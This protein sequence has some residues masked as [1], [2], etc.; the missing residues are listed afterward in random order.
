MILQKEKGR[1]YGLDDQGKLVAE[2]TY[3]EDGPDSLCIDHTFVDSSL[4]GQ[5][6]AGKLTEAAVQE[7]KAQ[8]KKVTATWS[9]AQK[10]LA[11][12]ENSP[13]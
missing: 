4:R 9:Y 7:I 8:G 12:H 2:I 1:I 13:V 6:M 3:Q 10:W 5:G 11:D